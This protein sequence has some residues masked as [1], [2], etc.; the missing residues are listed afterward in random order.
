[1]SLPPPLVTL[2]YPT[3]LADHASGHRNITVHDSFQQTFERTADSLLAGVMN[4]L[5]STGVKK[6]VVT[7][8]PRCVLLL[9]LVWK[10]TPG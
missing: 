10:S 7:A 9:V 5:K 2:L 6:T 1:M 3:H 4:G 8:Q